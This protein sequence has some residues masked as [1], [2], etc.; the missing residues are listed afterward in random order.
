MVM[1]IL[2]KILIGF[3]CLMISPCCLAYYIP[4]FNE[5]EERSIAV[6]TQ[7]L[8]QATPTLFF[9]PFHPQYVVD[10]AKVYKVKAGSTDNTYEL[11]RMNADFEGF[12]KG[13]IL[14]DFRN[15]GKGEIK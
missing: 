15:C 3:T 2:R 6:N 13:L 9:I 12:G 5:I 14:F 11:L 8:N 4:S 7:L 10:V 1:K